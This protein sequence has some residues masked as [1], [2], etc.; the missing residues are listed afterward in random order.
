MPSV[1]TRAL[2]EVAYEKHSSERD[3][4]NNRTLARAATVSA[5]LMTELAE[6]HAALQAANKQ[7]ARANAHGA[8]LMAELELKDETISRRNDALSEANTRKVALV[9]RHEERLQELHETLERLRVLEGVIPICMHCH[10]IRDEAQAWTK[11]ETYFK[12]YAKMLFSHGLCPD[13]LKAHYP[14]C[15]D[16]HPSEAC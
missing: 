14:E 9:A 7:L 4:M 6:K 13:C 5:E 2:I 1:P 3:A 11:L 8:E 16:D 10:K 12:R 15:P